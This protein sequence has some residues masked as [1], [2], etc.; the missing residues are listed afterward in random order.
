MGNNGSV[1]PW[2]PDRLGHLWSSLIKTVTLVMGR[3]AGFDR[4]LGPEPGIFILPVLALGEGTFRVPLN[5]TS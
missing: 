3:N 1:S 5:L 2:S 4:T